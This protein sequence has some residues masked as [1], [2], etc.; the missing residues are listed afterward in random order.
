MK[1]ITLHEWKTLK[2]HGYTCRI[3]GHRHILTNSLRH[4]TEL[5]PVEIDWKE[6]ARLNGCTSLKSSKEQ[7]AWDL[8]T[9]VR[10]SMEDPNVPPK[11]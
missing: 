10:E 3:D 2:Q 7:K 9:Q 8:A 1:R 4:G 6:T 11:W 5:V